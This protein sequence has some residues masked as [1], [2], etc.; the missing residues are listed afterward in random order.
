MT[1]W[2]D[3]SQTSQLKDNKT[4]GKVCPRNKFQKEELTSPKITI[5]LRVVI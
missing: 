4:K 5:F 1:S 3:T 2:V